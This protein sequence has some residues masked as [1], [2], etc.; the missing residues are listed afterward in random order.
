VWLPPE[1][2]F[3]ALRSGSALQPEKVGRYEVG[4]ETDLGEGRVISLRRFAERSEDQITTL[5]GLDPVSQVGHY[6]I[7]SPGD[8]RVEGW[9][10][11]IGGRL[12]EHVT[13]N[14]QYAVMEA[15]WTR[16]G[17]LSALRRASPSSIRKGGRRG[18]DFSASLEADLPASQ[19]HVSLSLR[20]SNEFSAA[21]R[22]DWLPVVGGRFKI[23]VRQQLPYQPLR[24][25]EL[26][27]LIT[28]RTLMRDLG[29]EGSLYDEL[30]TVR[31]P[32]RLTSGVQMRF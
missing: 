1:R 24:G 19:T 2:T 14:V 7:A 31:P 30:L 22:G 15:E 3:S 29:D 18:H 4:F 8:V 5:F 21:S 17:Q 26:N 12:V 11:G 10:L 13:G 23:E 6:Y 32:L 27:L 9:S 20:A 16:A 28:V 25:G